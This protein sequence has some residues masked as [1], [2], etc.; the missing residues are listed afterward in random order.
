M[1]VQRHPTSRQYRSSKS[2]CQRTRTDDRTPYSERNSRSSSIF[3]SIRTSRSLEANASSFRSPFPRSVTP[4]S[5]MKYDQHPLAEK[6][7]V[8]CLWMDHTE[9]EQDRGRDGGLDVEDLNFSPLMLATF[10]IDISG[11][12]SMNQSIRFLKPGNRL[13]TEGSRTSVAYRGMRPTIDLT[14]SCWL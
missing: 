13:M 5:V 8:P 2:K 7:C 12:F 11:R 4:S 10:R 3:S 6:M 14:G 9:K 1:V